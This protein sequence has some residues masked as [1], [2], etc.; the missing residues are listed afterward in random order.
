MQVDTYC[1]DKNLFKVLS[2]VTI[3]FHCFTSHHF[4][5]IFTPL[6]YHDIFKDDY[7]N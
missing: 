7:K 4:D 2:F 5:N 1:Y 6:A 3:F